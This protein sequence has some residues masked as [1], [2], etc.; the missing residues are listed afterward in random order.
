ML[1][2]DY[3]LTDQPE[4]RR[5]TQPSTMGGPL[6]DPG[7]CILCSTAVLV[8]EQKKFKTTDFIIV[9]RIKKGK[10]MNFK[11][12]LWLE[13]VAWAHKK[14]F[15]LSHDCEYNIAWGKI[16]HCLRY[17]LFF[18]FQLRARCYTMLRSL[19]Q[20]KR[21]VKTLMGLAPNVSVWKMHI[22][23]QLTYLI[24]IR[25]HYSYHISVKN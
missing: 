4:L 1:W 16:N 21:E 20:Y 9:C 2:A 3:W 24:F 17:I 14:S 19:K 10:F 11:H 18:V 23:L 12:K 7:F 8:V 13:F 15:Q 6:C 22:I 5:T 25:L